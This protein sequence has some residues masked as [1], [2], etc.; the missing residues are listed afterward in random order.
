MTAAAE[1]APS[2][3][4]DESDGVGMGGVM[5]ARRS[6]VVAVGQ[7][8]AIGGCPGGRNRASPLTFRDAAA[9]PIL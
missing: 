1:A 7:N 2:R 3:G 5:E 8:R 9:V 6:E 4:G